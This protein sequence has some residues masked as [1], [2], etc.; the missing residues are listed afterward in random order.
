MMRDA[1]SA[2]LCPSVDSRIWAAGRFALD[3]GCDASDRDRV[4]R[5]T[6]R[7]PLAI[8]ELGHGLV[9]TPHRDSEPAM[10]RSAPVICWT[11]AGP[12]DSLT[13]TTLYPA[14]GRSHTS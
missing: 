13:G 6:H 7:D 5:Q 14:P 2:L 1:S 9:H 12:T 8:R 10:V 3:R 4:C 11:V